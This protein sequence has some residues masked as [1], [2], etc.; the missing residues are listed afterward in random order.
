[1]L[2]AEHDVGA[3]LVL[4]GEKLV[5]I[6]TER[7]II[8]RVVAAGHNPEALPVSEFMTPSPI[9]CSHDKPFSHALMTMAE[10]RFRHMPVVDGLRVVGVV[11]MRDAHGDEHQQLERMMQALDTVA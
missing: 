2:L 7:D 8:K 4:D 3:V 1:M 6:V 11:S 10:H 9:V 5:G